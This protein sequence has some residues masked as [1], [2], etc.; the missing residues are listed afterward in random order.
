M[1]ELL[2]PFSFLVVSLSGWMNQHQQHV[3]HYLM[4]ENRV[5]REQIGN[6]RMRFSDEHRRRLAAKA[7]TIGR[8][9]LHEIATIVTPETL[10]AWHRKLIANKYDGSAK[11][12]LGRPRTAADIA[13]VVTRMAIENRSWGY[14]RIQ[15]AL[16]N[17]GH[18][19]AFKTIANILK[20]HGIEPAPERSRKTSWKEFLTRHWEQIVASDF[21]TIEV[22]TP[23]GLKRFVVLFFIE[24]SIRRVEIG[25]VANKANGL[26]MAQIGRYVTDEVDG[27]F[28]GKRYLIHDRDP[29][30]TQEFLRILAEVGVESVKL[31]PRSPNLNAYAERFVRTIKESCLE[32]MILFGEDALRTS[33]RQFVDHYHLER[34]HQALKNRLII[35]M[36]GTLNSEGR[37]ERRQRLG[38]LLNYYYRVA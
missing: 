4:E 30:Y 10:L 35:P 37:I 17:L 16:S 31:P 3:I 21:F 5:L 12:G 23:T 1:R 18:L 19:L 15:G 14:R 9:L 26:W 33:I 38:G 24:L 22:W 29:L 6:R 20:E 25:G 11:R 7:K 28:K 13:A 2:D 8:R 32:Q 34:N 27:F 36:K